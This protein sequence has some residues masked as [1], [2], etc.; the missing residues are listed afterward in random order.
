MGLLDSAATLA[1]S[2]LRLDP[3]LGCNFYVEI[4]GLITGQF[5]AVSGL[6]SSI[7]V[8]EFT[9]GG[10][11]GYTHKLPGEAQY[12]NLT[13][14]KGVTDLTAMWDWYA[15]VAE[16]YTIRRN[17]SVTILDHGRWPVMW[18]DVVG[19]LPVK[20]TGPTFDAARGEVGVE[21]LELIHNGISKPFFSNLVSDIRLSVAIARNFT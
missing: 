9:E 10:N 7:K 1:F 5:S 2:R 21:S 8:H 13:L 14:S 3:H 17:L 6:E 19:A 16:G 20:W 4:D 18:W 11:N 12:S 15:A